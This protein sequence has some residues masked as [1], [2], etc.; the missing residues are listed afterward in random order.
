MSNKN[1]TTLYIGVTNDLKRRVYEH[2]I[3]QGSKFTSKYILCDLVYYEHIYGMQNAIN[4][5]KQLKNWHKKWKWNLI[6][7]LNP[8]L[9]DLAEDWYD[10]EMLKQVQ[11]DV[12]Q[13]KK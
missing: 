13:Y 9:K 11:H 10:D 2:K 1:R 8:E 6:K 3:G 5:E 12:I 7:K 4:R